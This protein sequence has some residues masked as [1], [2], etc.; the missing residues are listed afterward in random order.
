MQV[1]L[2]IRCAAA[3][4]STE[5]I[6]GVGVILETVG[7]INQVAGV[8]LRDCWLA[9]EKPFNDV[10]DVRTVFG[11]E[12]REAAQST[13]DV[14]NGV[15]VSADAGSVV[16]LVGSSLPGGKRAVEVRLVV[17]VRGWGTDKL[18][19]VVRGWCVRPVGRRGGAPQKGIA[20]RSC[21]RK[22]RR[23]VFRR[24]VRGRAARFDGGEGGSSLRRSEGSASVLEERERVDRG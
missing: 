18:R 5:T 23:V 22:V 8:D 4:V 17:E 11:Q 16:H 15:V 1:A 19:V 24:K 2:E 7:Q 6:C 12:I 14:V 13:G 9:Q 3:E 20:T 21:W 10:G